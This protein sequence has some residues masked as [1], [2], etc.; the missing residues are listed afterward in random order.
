MT[1]NYKYGRDK[2]QKVARAL[3]NK[4]ASVKVSPGSKSAVDLKVVFPS[5]TKWYVQVKSTRSAKTVSPTSK[6][7]GR[8]KQ[9]ATKSSATPV[10]AKVTP[11]G[12]EYK[13]AR[14][15]KTLTPPKSK[16]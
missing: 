7:I 4:G 13:S 12:I 10:I 2:E 3:R 9:V 15:T 5:G 8:L 14:S 1:K 16:K 11:K 6:E